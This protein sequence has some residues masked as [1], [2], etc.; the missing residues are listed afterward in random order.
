MGVSDPFLGIQT[1]H[2][3]GVH[4]LVVDIKLYSSAHLTPQD[5]PQNPL[6][7][8]NQIP[9]MPTYAPDPTKGLAL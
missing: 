7:T 8:F 6:A 5:D 1:K 9:C 3:E 2:K 4:P